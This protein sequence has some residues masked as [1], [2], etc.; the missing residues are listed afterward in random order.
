V[1]ATEKSGS[2]YLTMNATK[3]AMKSQVIRINKHLA[4]RPEFTS[5]VIGA[6]QRFDCADDRSMR[7]SNVYRARVTWPGLATQRG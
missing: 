4:L 1:N 3:D 2:W 5:I 6:G 7:A